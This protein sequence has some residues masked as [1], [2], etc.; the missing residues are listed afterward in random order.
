M[1]ILT[2]LRTPFSCTGLMGLLL[3]VS[4]DGVAIQSP[5]AMDSTSNGP[6]IK[7]PLL[8]TDGPLGTSVQLPIV[9]ASAT[10]FALEFS[11]DLQHWKV[12]WNYHVRSADLVTI[13]ASTPSQ[14]SKACRFYRLRVPGDL[15]DGKLAEWKSRGITSYRYHY[16]PLIGFCN[17][18]NSANVTVQ[19]GIVVGVTDAVRASGTPEPNPNLADFPTIEGLFQSVIAAEQTSDLVWVGVQYDPVLSYPTNLAFWANPDAGHGFVISQFEVLP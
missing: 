10:D 1:R 6:A 11:N 18:I 13:P 15:V 3:S 14:D 4:I 19:N 16:A 8:G 17:C 7:L 12:L 9:P 5:I 2:R